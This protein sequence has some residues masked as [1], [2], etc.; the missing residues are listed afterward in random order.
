MKA[1]IAQGRDAAVAELVEEGGLEESDAGGPGVVRDVDEKDASANGHSGG[2]G[3]EGGANGGL[4]EGD[5]AFLFEAGLPVTGADEEGEHVAKG[6]GSEPAGGMRDDFAGGNGGHGEHLLGREGLFAA[7][8]SRN[9]CVVRNR[10][11]TGEHGE[12]LEAGAG[13]E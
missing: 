11:H 4:P 7:D 2:M 6:E 12:G 9:G 3:C 5:G 13:D 1:D 8:Y 10:S